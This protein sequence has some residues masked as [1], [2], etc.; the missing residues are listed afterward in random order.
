MNVHNQCVMNVPSMCG[1]D[2]TERRGRLF[3]KCEVTA[4]KLQV[5]GRPHNCPSLKH[6]LDLMGGKHA[7]CDIPQL[8]D[9]CLCQMP[10]EDIFVCICVCHHRQAGMRV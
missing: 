4:D 10:N 3:L 7:R 6:T 9:V 5:T 2:H 1:T 8:V